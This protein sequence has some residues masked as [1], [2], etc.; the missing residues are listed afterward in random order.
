M[1]A[2]FALEPGQLLDAGKVRAGLR[3]YLG[4]AGGID[5]PQTFG[6]R[7]TDMLGRIGPAPLS[8][9]DRIRVGAMTGP[10]PALGAVPAEGP[11][12]ELEVALLLG[13]REEWIAA[14]SRTAL[15][16]SLYTVTPDS[17]RVGV[18]LDGAALAW[19]R[20]DELRS[21]GIVPGAV[22]VPRSGQPVLL[23]A[24]CPTTGGYPVIGVVPE[25]DLDRVAQLRPGGRLRFRPAQ[26]A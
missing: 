1:N 11:A 4:L 16:D 6:S 7:S 3:T 25:R 13:P 12:S 8:A 18:R 26:P 23:L 17:N 22:Q 24:D 14:R 21:E 20:E 10:E 15:A 5:S 9:G 19:A 2:P